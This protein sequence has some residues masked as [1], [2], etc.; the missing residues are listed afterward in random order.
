MTVRCPQCG[1]THTQHVS[2]VATTTAG[3][4]AFGGVA[5]TLTRAFGTGAAGGAPFI[6]SV[7]VSS[8]F[9][10]LAGSLLGAKVGSELERTMP[11]TYRCN[12][13]NNRFN[14]MHYL[15]Q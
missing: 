14:P 6:A 9:S 4:G 11:D 2:G 8:L 3:I 10:G 5:A 12:S 13:C 7:L 1:S 15:N